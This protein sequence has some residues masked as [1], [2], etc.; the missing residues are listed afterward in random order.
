MG[1]SSGFRKKIGSNVG[2]NDSGKKGC[3]QGEIGQNVNGFELT[4]AKQNVTKI[5]TLD[6]MAV[7]WV[8]GRFIKNRL[9]TSLAPRG[10]NNVLTGASLYHRP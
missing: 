10:D 2:G 5:S 8:G 1:I 9:Q 4:M 3:T 7:H 6:S